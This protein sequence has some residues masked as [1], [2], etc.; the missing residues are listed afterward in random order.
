MILFA[1]YDLGLILKDASGCTACHC[2]LA[3]WGQGIRFSFFFSC[4]L[5]FV[6][7]KLGGFVVL[8]HCF[9]KNIFCPFIYFF[10]VKFT[11]CW[12]MDSVTMGVWFRC[13]TA[14]G[15]NAL[16]GCGECR[17]VI[18]L[19]NG[20]PNFCSCFSALPWDAVCLW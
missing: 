18:C 9:I 3:V 13:M 2:M 17:P 19:L 14:I 8:C 20:L 7:E 15:A 5:L 6:F 4:L 10:T 12:M 1:S 16:N 11:V